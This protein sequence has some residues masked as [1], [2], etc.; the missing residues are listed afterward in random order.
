MYTNNEEL[1]KTAASVKGAL[2]TSLRQ[3]SSLHFSFSTAH[4][5]LKHDLGYHPLHKLQ[6]LQIVQKSK[7]TNFA[8]WKDFCEQFLAF[9]ITRRQ[10]NFF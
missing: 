10:Q 7:E 2:Q 4:R 1:R 8:R 6:I 5:M 3:H 9:V